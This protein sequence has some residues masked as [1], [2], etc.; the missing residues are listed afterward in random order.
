MKTLGGS[1]GAKG[2]G[3]GVLLRSPGA[4]ENPIP[5]LLAQERKEVHFFRREVGDGH[6]P[7]YVPAGRG[8]PT[9]RRGRP[10]P[11][12]LRARPYVRP[13]SASVISHLRLLPWHRGTKAI[14]PLTRPAPPPT[15]GLGANA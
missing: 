5:T 12:R 9:Q 4:P 11:P 7:D 14:A 1:P 8:R 15:S 2:G 10:L 3:A 13:S 6:K